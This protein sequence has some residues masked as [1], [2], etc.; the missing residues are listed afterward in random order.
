MNILD[1]A[2]AAF[3]KQNSPVEAAIADFKA[4]QKP[5]TNVRL[6][7]AIQRCIDSEALIPAEQ[8]KFDPLI[9]SA[10]TDI[11]REARRYQ[12]WLVE[13]Q[14]TRAAKWGR[15]RLEH[16]NALKTQAD[17]D[18][19]LAKCDADTIYWFKWWAWSTDPRPNA[20][21]T[22]MPLVLFDFQE[23]Y[24]K[25]LEYTAFTLRTSGL[26]EKSRDMGATVIWVDWDAK[27]WR[28]RDGFTSLLSAVDEDLVD[29]KKDPD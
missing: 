2:L 27:H 25:W 19:E 29:S 23:K 7:E 11:E 14:L 6:R 1:R 22:T 8:A 3:D 15:R 26:V 16:L 12:R 5:V 21:L 4:Q 9:E 20:P 10:A 24:V 28:F 18:A 13:Q 17:W